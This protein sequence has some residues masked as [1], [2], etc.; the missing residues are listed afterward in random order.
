[1]LHCDVSVESIIIMPLKGEFAGRLI[2]FDY[3]TKL[4]NSW[5]TIE[6]HNDNSQEVRDLK[7][8]VLIAWPSTNV[9]VVDELIKRFEVKRD[10]F[11]YIH[12]VMKIRAAHFDLDKNREIKLSDIGWH[13]RVGLNLA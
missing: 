13:H 8:L 2:D 11:F 7:Q 1:M 12:N 4:V 3:A 10:D 9:E 6:A 5:R